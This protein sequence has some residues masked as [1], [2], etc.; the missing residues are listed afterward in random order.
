MTELSNSNGTGMYDCW[1]CGEPIGADEERIRDFV[2]DDGDGG[3]TSHKVMICIPCWEADGVEI[4]FL[5][6]LGTDPYDYRDQAEARASELGWPDPYSVRTFRDGDD[7][8]VDLTWRSD[9]DPAAVIA[10]L[11]GEFFVHSVCMIRYTGPG[12]TADELAGE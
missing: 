6:P 9:T 2:G 11:R 5:V 8:V 4:E 12:S 10:V 3:Q 1:R 7:V